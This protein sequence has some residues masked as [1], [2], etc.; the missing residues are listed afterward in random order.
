MD[1]EAS[2]G[3]RFTHV[4]VERGKPVLDSKRMRRRI[5]QFVM[6]HYSYGTAIELL[7]R[8]LGVDIGFSAS[9]LRGFYENSDVKDILDSITIIYWN[10]FERDSEYPSTNY[11]NEWL[12]N[13]GRILKEENVGYVLDKHCGVHYSIDEEFNRARAASIQGIESARYDAVRHEFEKSYLALDAIPP[14]T[15]GAVRG[16]FESVEILFRLICNDTKC[17]RLG[18]AEIR[19]F[20]KPKFDILYASDTAE[21]NS[22]GLLLISMEN[23]VSAVHFYR[24][25][26]AVETPR[27]PPIEV[28]LVMLT[29]AAAYL[30]W[31]AEIDKML[32]TLP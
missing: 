19:T 6:K 10:I 16:S 8:E 30:R 13:I 5:Y 21:R 3:Q 4:Y 24:H 29:Q 20:L 2:V 9:D 14:D 23:W 17:Q 7:H 1:R 11:A 31:L 18:T 12:F 27:P 28:C 26:Q 15:K 22:A 25:G 32:M